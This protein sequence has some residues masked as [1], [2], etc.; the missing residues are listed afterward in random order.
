MTLIWVSAGMTNS[1]QGSNMIHLNTVIF[2][3]LSLILVEVIIITRE[4]KG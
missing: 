1:R 3:L 2:V 4:K